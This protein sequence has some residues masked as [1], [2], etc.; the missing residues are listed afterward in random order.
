MAEEEGEA[1]GVGLF[2]GSRRSAVALLRT[3]GQ[4]EVVADADGRRWTPSCVAWDAQGRVV[5]GCSAAE[6]ARLDPRGVFFDVHLLLA[7]AFD[8]LEVQALAARVPYDVV[9][10]D[11]RPHVAVTSAQGECQAM[12]PEQVLALLAARLKQ[13]A[14][15]ALGHEVRD[16]VVTVSMELNDCLREAI[17]AVGRDAGLDVV[18]VSTGAV[19]ACVGFA[20]ALFVSEDAEEHLLVVVSRDGD[21]VTTTAI[22]LEEGIYE[23]IGTKNLDAAAMLDKKQTP[24]ERALLA[25]DVILHENHQKRQVIDDVYVV[26][27]WEAD[28]NVSNQILEYTGNPSAKIHIEVPDAFEMARGAA[29]MSHNLNNTPPIIEISCLLN[30]FVLSMGVETAGGIFTPVVRRGTTIPI[31]KSRIFT[32]LHELQSSVVIKVFEGERVWAAHSRCLGQLELHNL[33]RRADNRLPQIKVTFDMDN[34][35]SLVVFAEELGTDNKAQFNL[36]EIERR[37]TNERLNEIRDRAEQHAEEDTAVRNSLSLCASVDEYLSRVTSYASRVTDEY[38]IVPAFTSSLVGTHADEDD[39]IRLEMASASSTI[40]DDHVRG[41]PDTK[42][43]A[44]VEEAAPDMV[45]MDSCICS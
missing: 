13:I 28:T 40:M 39:W 15:D 37:L 43:S 44:A 45:A 11:G 10:I 29:I 31:V 23:V 12:S 14:E 41:V 27:D 19:C 4:A 26:G 25:V 42:P 24:F 20:G 3:G 36:S 21:Y 32:P 16:V 38:G 17:K 2:L 33:Q 22:I 18:R 30:F 9:D 34:M 5:V 6:R 35:E 7:R 8:D 1:P